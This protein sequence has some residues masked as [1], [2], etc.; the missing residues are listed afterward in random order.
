MKPSM[1]TPL[2]LTLATAASLPFA[3][4]QDDLKPENP[5]RPP[6]A[7]RPTD[8]RPDAPRERR[9]DGDRPA[10]G[11]PEGERRPDGERRPGGDRRPDG[12]RAP[13]APRGEDRRPDGPR[14]GA[15]Q[16]DAPRPGNDRRDTPKP[17]SE[18]RDG[19]RAEA[20]GHD[21]PERDRQRTPNPRMMER[22]QKPTAYLGVVTGQ[23]SPPLGIQVGLPE[24]FG[25][26]VEEVVP[27]SPAARA[28]VQR[29][30]VLKQLND[31]QL[32]D[33]NQLAVLVRHAGKDA[34]VS[35]T[36]IRKGDEQKLSVKVGERMLPERRP[37][38]P[39]EQMMRNFAPMRE[40][41]EQGAKEMQERMEKWNR[42]SGPRMKEFQE[43]MKNY[44]ERLREFQ[45]RSRRGGQHPDAPKPP[46]PPRF[47]SPFAP[48]EGPR[49]FP[50]GAHPGAEANPFPPSGAPSVR[51]EQDGNVTTWNTANARAVM[52]DA[53][54]EV[55]MRSENGQ[56]TVTARSP[57]GEV[58]FTGL[59]DTEEQRDAIPEA[60]RR[61]L[62]HM[63]VQSHLQVAGAP[64]A[65]AATAGDVIDLEVVEAAEEE[66]REIQ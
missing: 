31:Q 7:E 11:A 4:A 29:F 20:R 63:D 48:G 26:V 61:K 46:A 22:P 36:V 47:D 45:E 60:V 33:P 57:G 41:A 2:L 66:E 14:P 58:I 27:D 19:P 44:G 10:A 42:E 32:I 54:G 25:L 5:Q 9:P 8:R 50:P 6:D 35:L 65:S 13:D 40:R 39:M 16:P 34:E 18:H 1:K 21:G 24:G 17:E 56:R 51:V 52:K 30:D 53:E 28:G 49:P 43:Q 3:S 64:S 38:D 59:I 23:V 12:E 15:R 37:M 62:A 55:E